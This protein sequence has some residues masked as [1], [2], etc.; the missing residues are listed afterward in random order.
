MQH[1]EELRTEVAKLWADFKGKK[2]S[3][4]DAKVHLGFCRVMIDTARVD[5]ANQRL[6]LLTAQ[7]V[8]EGP[9]QIDT[10]RKIR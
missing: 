8:K 10:P 5:L 2:F 4:Q 3:A 1:M 7:P 9:R 6:R